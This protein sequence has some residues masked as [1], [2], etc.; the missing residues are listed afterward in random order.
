[1]K[2]P[3]H[4]LLGASGAHRWLNCPGSFQLSLRVPPRPSSI[5]AATGTLAHHYIE[6]ALNTALNANTRP[7]DL[8]VSPAE[9]GHQWSLEGHEIIVDQTFIDG[10]N[11]MLAYVHEAA[12][13]S[14]WFCVEFR[15]HLDDYFLPNTP[16]VPLFG[17]VDVALLDLQDGLLEIID[18][19]NGAGVI[20]SP[21]DN[22]QMLYYLAGVLRELPDN[23]HRNVQ[24]VKLT[25]VQPNAP[26]HQPIRSWETSVVDVLM[27]VREVLVPGVEA[28][29]HDDAPLV[30]GPWCKFCP[31]L[32]VCPRL[33]QDAVD[34]AKREFDDVKIPDDPAELANALDIADRAVTWATALQAHAFEQLKRQVRIPGWELVPTRPS[35]HWVL[36]E[37]NTAAALSTAGLDDSVIFETRLRSPAQTEKAL[38]GSAERHAWASVSDSLIESRSSG[39]KL[40]RSDKLI[41]RRI[42]V[43][44]GE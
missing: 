21:R 7:G 43:I 37:K 13:R 29:G 18:Y 35:R 8:A 38:K 41:L 4:S 31:A 34:M 16:P 19:K 6:D 33:I 36:D 44:D 12:G 9:L 22:P 20:V 32:H 15:V 1:M 23:Q 17:R 40:A 39:V 42:S 3:A 25:V 5:Y 24:R 28:A 10:V 26:G 2:L 30:P 14:D 27:W 11:C